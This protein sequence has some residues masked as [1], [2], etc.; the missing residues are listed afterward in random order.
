MKM[1][2]MAGLL[3]AGGMVLAVVLTGCGNFWQAPGSTST[4]TTSTCTAAAAPTTSTTASSLSSGNFYVVSNITSATF[5]VAGYSMVSGT[6]TQF[7]SAANVQGQ[8]YALAIDPAAGGYLFVSSTNGIYLYGI[9]SGTGALTLENN[10]AVVVQDVGAYAIQVVSTAGGEWLLDATNATSGQPYL[11]A[12]PLDSTTHIPT[13]TI[14]S[15]PQVKLVAGGSVST[16]G[17][18]VSADNTLIAVAEGSGGTQLFTFTASNTGRTSPFGSTASTILL[19]GSSALSVAF[20][21]QTTFLYIGESS[22]FTCNSNSGGLRMFPITSDVLGSEPAAS[23]YASGGTGP[24]AI[25]ASANGYVYVANWQGTST[26]NITPFL[27]ASGPALT[28]QSE[29]VATGTEPLGIIQDKN[30][31]YVLAVSN[32]AG[33][34][35]NAY[36]FDA[37]TTGQLDTLPAPA[38]TI[39]SGPV[40][41][42]AAP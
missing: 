8:A 36:T 18:A 21:P 27:L 37:T 1:G 25:L 4:G 17:M 14:S 34:P 39:G 38:T 41:I 20:S 10:S 26:G 3:V 31:K 30:S 11:F 42:V 28:V 6:L 40:A 12:Y 32:S 24:H 2:R 23:P 13:G 33:T 15:A 35:F 22:V 29:T 19:K 7:T 5:Q 9:D 16:G